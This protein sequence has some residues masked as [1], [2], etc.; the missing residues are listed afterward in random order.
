MKYTVAKSYHGIHNTLMVRSKNLSKSFLEIEAT[1]ECEFNLNRVLIMI[2]TFVIKTLLLANSFS[3]FSIKYKLN[4]S[5]GSRSLPK[6]PSDYTIL[7][8]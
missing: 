7:Y 8:N 4:F 5:N 2:R 3:T 6:I 1:I